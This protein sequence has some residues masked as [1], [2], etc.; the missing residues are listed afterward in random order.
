MPR[1]LIITALL[2]CI[3]FFHHFLVVKDF[4][5]KTKNEHGKIKPFWLWLSFIPVL[6]PILYIL[7]GNFNNEERSG[8]YLFFLIL[9][10]AFLI[11]LTTAPLR[12]F[13]FMACAVITFVLYFI[14]IIIIS[15]KYSS[16]LKDIYILLACLLGCSILQ[17]PTR[18]LTFSASLVSLPDFLFHLL[19]IIMGYLFYKSNRIIRI[20]ILAFSL[21]S[22][23]FL[24][25]KGYDM[26]IDK[27]NFGTFAGKVESKQNYDLN[28]QTNTGDSL[29]LSDFNG[30]YLLLD[31]WNTYCGV[32][33]K[34]MPKMQQLY[35]DFKQNPEVSIYAM[36][37]FMEKT[38]RN[39]SPENYASGSEILEK[40]GYSFPCIAIDIDN[41]VLKELGVN[42]YPTVLIFDKQSNLIFRGS[43]ESARNYIK[44]LTN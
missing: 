14:F 40:R 27:L 41:P 11:E 20:N 44:K 6:G 2:L 16:R 4:I 32:C 39:D 12:A 24:Y 33:Y 13:S 15:R 3:V 18:I 26:W 29:S 5:K 8:R 35:D 31:C 38:N 25:F 42:A 23:L 10:S 17:L 36:H 37:S 7:G 28:F 30:K 1:G 22:C 9:L 43:I 21:L 34:K 19:G